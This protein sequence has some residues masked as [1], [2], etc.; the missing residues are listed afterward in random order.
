LAL[1]YRAIWTEDRPQ[2]LDVAADTARRWLIDKGIELVTLPTTTKS[3]E[4][5]VTSTSTPGPGTGS[6]AVG[7]QTTASTRS[8]S[9][10]MR[11]L[12]GGP[13]LDHDPHGTRGSGGLHSLVD[14]ERH[15]DDPFLYVAFRS[16][17]LV[18][19]LLEEE[20]SRGSA[21]S[22]SNRVQSSYPSKGWPV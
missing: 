14:V 1:V 19:M 16:P 8:G 9:P 5:G 21:M 3:T 17:I 18:R 10:S 11:T 13:E 6:A 20:S 7:C 4:S 15:S 22:D 2:L 12:R